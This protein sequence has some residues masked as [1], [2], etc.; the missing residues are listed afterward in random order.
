MHHAF[1]A[2]A[3]LRQLPVRVES[4]AAYGDRLL[5]GT[6]SGALLVYQVA[7][8]DRDRLPVVTLVETKRA[9]A[10]RAVEQLGVIKEA[11]VLVCLADGLVTLFDLHTLSNATP[12]NNTKGAHVMAL[13]TGVEHIDGIPTLSSKL[14]V[15]AKRKVV[16]L[17]WRDS[18]FY[19]SFEYAAADRI[20]AMHFAAPGLLVLATAREFLTLQ[21]PRG[22]WDELFPADTASLRTVAGGLGPDGSSAAPGA[23]PPQLPSSSTSASGSGAGMW[24]SWALGLAGSTADVKTTIAPMPGERLLLCHMDIG[25]MVNSAGK[26][27][28]REYPEPMS[29]SRA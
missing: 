29:F 23:Q 10:R 26:L 13:H 14:A 5:L 20:V 2:H 16:V 11:G 24:G 21:L 12:L 28:R 25:V 9:F 27:C 15:Y 7:E 8:P 17:E 6:A 4:A 3:L 19:K 18:E 22:Q 1:T